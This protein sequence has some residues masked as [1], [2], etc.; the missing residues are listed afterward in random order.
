MPEK[1][2]NC[3]AG[4]GMPFIAGQLKECFMKDAIRLLGI[5]TLVAVIGFSMAACDDGG[6]PTINGEGS[7]SVGETLTLSGKVYEE[8]WNN[9]TNSYAE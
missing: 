6:G 7:T 4:D 5:I 8:K 1:Q 9:D 3:F 2:R